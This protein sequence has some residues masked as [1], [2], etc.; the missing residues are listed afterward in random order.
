MTD[1][2]AA[3]PADPAVAAAADP[4]ALPAD[5]APVAAAAPPVAADPIT[6]ELSAPEGMTLDA[7]AVTEFTAIAQELKIAPEKAQALADIAVKMQQRQVEQHAQ[8]QEAWVGEI[9]ADKD[10]G[11]DNFEANI[12]IARKAIERFG[13]P[14]LKAYLDQTGLGNFPPLIRAMHQI[15][16]AISDDGFVTGQ[17]GTGAPDRA[18]IMFPTMN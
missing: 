12:A 16:L 10:F 11:G 13:S 4:A 15:G 2:V 14:E 18:K 17:K 8:T 5:P 7:D 9:K 1:I 3:P 6:Y